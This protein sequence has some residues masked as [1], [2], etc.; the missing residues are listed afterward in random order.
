MNSEISTSGNQSLKNFYAL[1]LTDLESIFKA[2]GKEKFRAQQLFK[3]VYE[4]RVTDPELMTNLSKDFRKELQ[5]YIEFSLPAVVSHLKSVDGTQKFLFDIGDNKTVEAVLI[6]S[7]DRMTLCLSSEVGC[8]MACK[9][10]FTGKQKLQRRLKAEEIVGQ[11]VR[12]QDILGAEQRITNIVFMGMGEPLDNS[13]EVFKAI[14]IIH[15]PWGMNFSRRRVTVSTS[16][17]VPEMWKVA[18][19]KVRLAV[20]LNGYDDESRSHVMPINKKYPLKELMDACHEYVNQTKD[21]V[22]FEYVLL[23]GI[24]DQ[25]EHVR[26]LYQ[27]TK[28]IPCKINIIPFNEHPGSGFERPSDSQI[29]KVQNELM[30]LGAHV[31]LRRTMGRDIFAACGQLRSEY[32]N[33]PQQMDVSNSRLT[34]TLHLKKQVDSKSI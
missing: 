20:S 9:F 17:I 21:R 33:H 10:C 23:K 6:P 1:N 8:N 29:L 18:H 27:L 22:T 15:S 28:N 16:G 26:K 25:L 7:E 31:L 4:K 5:R 30:N 13:D 14:E 11:F 2:H 24:T 19:N 12:A 32:E 3:W 34:R